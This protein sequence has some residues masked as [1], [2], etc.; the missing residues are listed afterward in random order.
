LFSWENSISHPWNV[1]IIRLLNEK[2]R[3]YALEKGL[4]KLFHLL[5]PT[6]STSIPVT[7]VNKVLDEVGDVEKL[8]RDKLEYQQGLLR[9]AQRKIYS[10]QG[11]TVGASQGGLVHVVFRE[12]GPEA[13]WQ[14][15]TGIQMVVN[16]WLFHNGFSIGI[17]D[18]KVADQKTMSYIS[19]TILE[20]KVKV[21]ETD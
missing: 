21:A 12:K 9:R 6:P 18:T 15:F 10:M 20:R 13:T 17:G 8:I 1:A 19:Q 2:F 16:F 3:T 11:R 5:G 14:L 4:S 7:D